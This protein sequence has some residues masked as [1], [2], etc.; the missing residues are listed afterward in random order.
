MI[1]KV[2]VWLVWIADIANSIA[3]LISDPSTRRVSV[4]RAL[5]TGQGGEANVWRKGSACDVWNEVVRRSAV[6]RSE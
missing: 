4:T 1:A 3:A 5:G 2:V 6:M